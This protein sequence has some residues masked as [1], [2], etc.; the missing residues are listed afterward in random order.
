M[1]VYI[2]DAF[3]DAPF[4][5]NPAAVCLVE[6]EWDETMMQHIASEMNLSETAFVHV[7]A[8]WEEGAQSPFGLRWFTP[9]V[10]VDLCGH[11]TL[12]TA[13]VLRQC[14]IVSGDRVSFE[15]KSGILH[16]AYK[17]SGGQCEITLDFPASS[18]MLVED[19]A[20]RVR[21]EEA[22]GCSVHEVLRSRIELMAIVDSEQTVRSLEPN[23]EQLKACDQEAIGVLVTARAGESAHDRIDFVSRCF[24]PALGVNEDPVTG[25]AHCTIG[26]Y[27]GAKLG[28]LSLTGR[29]CSARGG[30]VKL[31]L[32]QERVY[33]TGTA[34][35]IMDGKFTFS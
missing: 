8:E 24:F 32:H 13:H 31:E 27:W 14:G 17:E 11:A 9:E 7:D 18:L 25:S 34:V 22:L 6:Q 5:G 26:P 33:L 3:T 1:K 2:V 28:R 16:A 29:Q 30:V 10:E 12:A 15:T 4:R 21:L 23:W 19:E 35:T 20:L